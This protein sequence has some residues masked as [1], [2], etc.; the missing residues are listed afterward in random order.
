MNLLLMAGFLGSGK[1]TQIIRLAEAV[2]AK[3]R[4]TAIL[5]NEIGE[6]GIDDRLMR[7][8][9]LNVWELMGGCICCTLTAGLLT[10]LHKLDREYDPDLVILEATGAAIPG[11]IL[12]S[13]QYFQGQPL[14][15]VRT[16]VVLD[17][18]RLPKI[19]QVLGP[20]MEKQ[21]TPADLLLVTKT[22]LAT[23]QEIA[24]TESIARQFNP[25]APLLRTSSGTDPVP[26]LI[27]E[28]LPW[29]T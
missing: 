2:S 6:I 16:T 7:Q 5:V 1:T 25:S 11:D 24:D 15:S 10:E 26:V 4:M 13:L 18:L 23:D 9:G 3:G 8:L 20:L 17:P 28:M 19:M 27:G 29:L 12:D 21:I 22:D 14:Q